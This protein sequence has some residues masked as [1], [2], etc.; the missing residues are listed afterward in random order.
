MKKIFFVVFCLLFTNSSFATAMVTAVQKIESK[1]DL[2]EHNYPKNQRL[3]EF[4]SLLKQ[5]QILA[6]KFPNKAEPLILQ[7]CIILTRAKIENSFNALASVRKA[8]NLLERAIAINPNA[9]QGSAFV[10]LGVLYYKVPGWPIAFGDNEKAE[11][12]LKK[13][14]SINPR[15]IDSNYYYAEYLLSQNQSEQAAR[16]LAKAIVAPLQNPKLFSREIKAK[17]K[18]AL[19]AISTLLASNGSQNSL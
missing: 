16:Y 3:K 19:K 17:A 1:W 4:S 10:T 8:R 15:G 9:N 7:A 14:L 2:I 13:A 5:T 6:D 11:K 18:E 12:M